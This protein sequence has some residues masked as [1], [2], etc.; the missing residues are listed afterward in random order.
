MYF[1]AGLHQSLPFDLSIHSIAF[2][3][4]EGGHIVDVRIVCR[5]RI[6]DKAEASQCWKHP[7]GDST[8]LVNRG[9]PGRKTV[10]AEG[11]VLELVKRRRVDRILRAGYRFAV[12]NG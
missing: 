4:I 8:K 7:G 11:K 1:L 10:P 2:G 12:F 9:L 5:D 3:L 6:P